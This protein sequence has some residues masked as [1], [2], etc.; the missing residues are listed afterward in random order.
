MRTAIV[1][2]LG[3]AVL[4]AGC[5]TSRLSPSP[6]LARADASSSVPLPVGPS[7]TALPLRQ[8]VYAAAA[9]AAPS[10]A[11]RLASGSATT[12]APSY[13]AVPSSGRLPPPVIR[14]G[15]A[16]AHVASA[17]PVRPAPVVSY[18]PA[19]PPAPRP[20]LA[21]PYRTVSVPPVTRVARPMRPPP[22]YKRT[23]ADCVT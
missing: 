15:C 23:A 7:P 11:P 10:A 21:R 14:G 3:A 20:V 2:A 9:P 13:A 12:G 5:S 18:V 4:T 1:L 19:P 22:V 8:P 6:T 16:P 17:P